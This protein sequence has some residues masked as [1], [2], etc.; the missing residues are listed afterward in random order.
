MQLMKQKIVLDME[1]QVADHHPQHQ[2]VMEAVI[3]QPLIK[4]KI[5]P[6]NLLNKQNHPYE[7]FILKNRIFNY[8]FY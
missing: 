2:A 6:V 4:L 1:L 5:K 3:K 7:I 8:S